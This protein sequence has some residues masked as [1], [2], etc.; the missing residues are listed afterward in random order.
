MSATN[1]WL[2]DKQT[3]KTVTNLL[4]TELSDG[5]V[6]TTPTDTLQQLVNKVPQLAPIV[7][8]DE[9]QPDSLWKFPD[10]NGT[11]NLKTIREIY[12][13][14]TT[15]GYTYRGIFQIRGDLDT[16]DLKACMNA[17]SSAD[18]FIL[19]DG[20]TYENITATTL[21]HTWDTTK[22]VVD[23]NGVPMRYIR[24]YT[25]T[26]YNIVPGWWRQFVWGIHELGNI[27]VTSSTPT[28]ASTVQHAYGMLY[29]IHAECLEIESSIS[30]SGGGLT[31]Q[32]IGCVKKLVLKNLPSA[33][34][35]YMPYLSNPFVQELHLYNVG[36]QALKQC[37]TVKTIV[38][39]NE[40]V[41]S[42]TDVISG[43]FTNQMTNSGGSSI[44]N[45]PNQ[46]L[47]LDL[48]K[49]INVTTMPTVSPFLKLKSLI[50]PPKI[51]TMNRNDF[52]NLNI[53]V[54][55]ETLTSITGG[56]WYVKHIVFTG[57]PTTASWVQNLY[58]CKSFEIPSGW[59][60]ALP[61]F[62]NCE[63][64][65]DVIVDMFENLADLTGQTAKAIILGAYHLS[66]LTAEEKAIATNKNWTLS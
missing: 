49:F 25:N 61:N 52:Y 3:L 29:A 58:C 59:N 22:D 54:L 18:T 9:W 20:T 48:S 47:T 7:Y 23:S 64:S 28:L 42:S 39:H 26:Q 11:E 40:I 56:T 51:T 45:F 21:E 15:T 60:V 32:M 27:N 34:G 6:A 37:G 24:V 50:L 8:S 62:S 66:L 36:T 16:F 55:P 33:T 38:F 57:I 30:S 65:K 1:K 43:F 10:P 44:S 17:R 63:F 13:E 14:D 4:R 53:L 46:I 5:G 2:Q 41:A 12:D 19:S 31:P 35:T